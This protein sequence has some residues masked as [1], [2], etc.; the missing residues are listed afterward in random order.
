MNEIIAVN[1]EIRAAFGDRFAGEKV[2]LISVSA[3]EAAIVDLSEDLRRRVGELVEQIAQE[4]PPDFAFDLSLGEAEPYLAIKFDDGPATMAGSFCRPI[5]WLSVTEQLRELDWDEMR[6]MALSGATIFNAIVEHSPDMPEYVPATAKLQAKFQKLTD[7]FH[8][9]P[10]DPEKVHVLQWNDMQGLHDETFE[11]KEKFVWS[12][13][14]LMTCGYH[15]I[16][17]VMNGRRLSAEQ[18]DRMKRA[19][20]KELEDMPISYAKASG[21]LFPPTILED[22]P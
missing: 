9:A 17:V 2:L 12:L 20:L 18:I 10:L 19:A 6:G 21:R 3:D 7:A 5:P 15:I 4:I 8:D 14:D 22:E 11:T 13:P 16:A 1:N